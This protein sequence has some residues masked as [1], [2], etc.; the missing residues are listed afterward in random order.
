MEN[1]PGLV[2]FIATVTHGGFANAARALGVS[3]AAVSKNVQRLEKNL[4]ARLL[5]RTTRRVA[6]TD[7][8]A[9]YYERC[10]PSVEN[11]QQAGDMLR[12]AR[13]KPHGEL[14]ISSVVGFGRQF[15]VPLLPG[16][17]KA[18]PDIV[19]DFRLEDRIAD[20][21]GDR[22]DI[23][24]RN[25]RLKDREVVAV[26]L[27]PMQLVVCGSPLYLRTHGAPRTP[28]ELADHQCINFRLE[29]SGKAFAWEFE[30][31]RSR[32]SLPVKGPLTVND[33]QAAC[34]AAIAGVGLVQVGAYLAAPHIAAGRLRTVLTDF[35]AGDRG[36]YLCYLNRA[37]LPRRIRVF[38]D[39]MRHRIDPADFAIKS[40]K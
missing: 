15:I 37:Q 7:E 33:P 11:L 14:R 23:A 28:D 17:L 39:Y 35:V 8:G 22:I 2:A 10:K 29:A 6:L 31:S 27:A 12:E 5:N 16:F 25:G 21:V 36:H 3:P 13:G 30:R 9:F 26:R 40:R 4:G 38:V 34:A 20:M 1:F 18:Y 19:L 24:I 32:F